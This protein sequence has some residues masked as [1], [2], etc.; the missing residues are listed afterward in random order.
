MNYFPWGGYL[1]FR[2]WPEYRVFIDGQTDFYGE[3]LTRTYEKILT[4]DEGWKFWLDKYQINWVIFPQDSRLIM[5]LRQDPGWECLYE[6][7]LATI[8]LRHHTARPQSMEKR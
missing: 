8:C 3:D 1:L 5:A 6:D 7:H 2:L 4:L